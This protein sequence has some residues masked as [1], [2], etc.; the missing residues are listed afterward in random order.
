MNTKHNDINK[1]IPYGESLRGFVNQKFISQS[2]L[3]RILKERGIFTL[4]SEKDFIVPI[5]QTLLLSP[6]EFDK[7]R[8]AFTAKED[9]EKKISRDINFVSD[10]QLFDPEILSINVTDFIKKELPTCTLEQPIR[11]KRVENNPNYLKADFIIQRKDINKSW[12]EQTNLFRGS[13]EFINDKGK[14]RAVITH[15]APE[16]KELA[17]FIMNQQIKKYK[18][19]KIIPEKEK[20]R[21]IIFNDFSNENRFVFFYRLTNHL[22]SEFFTCDNIKDISIKPEDGTLPKEIKWMEKMQK[23]VLTGEALDKKYFMNESK[24]H[25]DLILWSIDAS[26]TYNYR[27]EKGKMIVSMGFPDYMTSKG[28]K[29]EFELN[30]SSL[31]PEKTLDSKTRR[32]LKD[33]LL[34]EMD[35]QKSI[36]YNKYLEYKR[37]K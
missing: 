13:I 32:I 31:S 10:K 17:I 26:F 4:N 5:L 3:H 36:V 28:S 25:K 34:S 37:K 27:G 11:F 1:I 24:Y 23:I 16:T 15:T 29:S 30:I 22:K 21:E 35:R 33:K 12:Y 6:K 20:L 19:R 2:E 8:D 7:I 9:N 18:E 14:G